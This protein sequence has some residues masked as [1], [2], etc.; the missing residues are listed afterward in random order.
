MPV[1]KDNAANRR[2]NRVGL[3]F[4]N[5]GSAPDRY[6]QIKK[7]EPKKKE[8]IITEKE[9]NETKKESQ[10]RMKKQYEDFSREMAE[11]NKKETKK[12]ETKKILNS[13]PTKMIKSKE[14]PKNTRR[15]KLVRIGYKGDLKDVPL[16]VERGSKGGLKKKKKMAKGKKTKL[17]EA[18]V[19]K[20]IKRIEKNKYKSDREDRISY[21]PDNRSDKNFSGK[22]LV[23]DAISKKSRDALA[24]RRKEAKE[25]RERKERQREA[26]RKMGM[27]KAEYM[28]MGRA[29]GY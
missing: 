13:M 7:K 15:R 18:G 19:R 25:E 28:R 11:I 3:E 24:K 2:L 1:Y 27:S 21:D 29:L 16:L 6:V 17:D 20:G 9:R 23:E 12:K 14:E 5:R 26:E 10:A 4:K 22:A 8:V